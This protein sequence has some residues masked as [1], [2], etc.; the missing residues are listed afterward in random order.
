[1]PPHILSR[2]IG[3]AVLLLIL[4]IAAAQATFVVPPGHRGILVTLGKVSQDFLPE[5]FHFKSPFISSVVEMSVRQRTVPLDA[6]CISRDLQEV[7]TRMQVLYRVPE[8]SVVQIFQKYKGDPFLSLI[9]P[10]VDEALKEVTKEHTAQEIVQK[11]AEIKER[12]L[13][14]ARVKIGV[15]LEVVDVVVEDIA[16][17]DKLESAIERKMVQEQEANKAVFQQQQ[18]QIEADTAIV[19]A[20]GEAEAIQIRGSALNRNP[21]FIDLEIVDRWNG[22]TPRVVG[23]TVGGAQML[24]P[25]GRVEPSALTQP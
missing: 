16:L 17:S 19:R 18:T 10:R 13:V 22:I 20:K 2:L 21:A 12:A 8:A 4:V 9:A 6:V 1:M 14:A 25:L 24:L 11:R 5:G 15:I 7:Q 3:G 23:G